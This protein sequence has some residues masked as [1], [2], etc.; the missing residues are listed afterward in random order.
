[1]SIL[2]PPVPPTTTIA[3]TES[4]RPGASKGRQQSAELKRAM[5]ARPRSQPARKPCSATTTP[6]DEPPTRSGGRGFIRASARRAGRRTT[7]TNPQ[8]LRPRSHRHQRRRIP[9]RARSVPTLPVVR[10]RE[11]IDA[12]GNQIAPVHVRPAVMRP[13]SVAS[14]TYIQFVNHVA[15]QHDSVMQAF[16]RRHRPASF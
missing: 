12:A 15:R 3:S 2:V 7:A 10:D 5:T 11:T 1:M 8:P 14:H 6:K 13:N 4:T 9:N 16:H